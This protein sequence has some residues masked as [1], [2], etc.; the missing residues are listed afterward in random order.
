MYEDS[1]SYRL[2]INWGSLIIKAIL[3]ILFVMLILWLFPVPKL[4][5]FYNRVFSDNLKTMEEAAKNYY[6]GD[7]L[8]VSTGD[9]KTLTLEDMVN[10]NLIVEFVDK[11]NNKCSG[12]NSFAT[13]TKTDANKYVLKVQ[14]SCGTETD[15]ILENIN[16]QKSCNYASC[17]TGTVDNSENVNAGNNIIINNDED[18][19]ENK[20]LENGSYDKDGNLV[21]I[22]EYEFKKPI[23]NTSTNYSCPDGF[24]LE[25]DRCYKY[26]TGETI[27]AT[28]LYFEDSIKIEDA[29]KNETGEYNVY[30]DVVKQEAGVI[31]SCPDG[32]TRNGDVCYKYVEATVNPGSTKYSC[33]AGYDLNGKKCVKVIN[34]TKETNNN[35][36]Y[37]CANG[38]NL[39]GTVCRYNATYHN[40]QQT[41]TTTPITYSCD[42]GGSLSGTT[43]TVSSS[44]TATKNSYWSNPSVT[45]SKSALSEY[46]NGT[47]KRVLANKSCNLSG[48]TYTY[49]TYNL[50]T[51]YSCPNGGS[52]SNGVCYTSTSYQ[53]TQHGGETNCSTFNGYY[54]CDNG[55]NLEGSVCRYDASKKTNTTEK[56]TCPA[57]Y[58]LT[59][60]NKCSSVIDATEDTTETTYSCP[61]GYTKEGT[62]CYR[63]E[64]LNKETKYEYVCPEGYLTEG[65]GDKKKCYKKQAS[66][67]EYYCEEEDAVL[68]GNKCI[69]KVP[70][71]LKGYTCPT[72]YV[73]DGDNC[74]KKTT[75]C[76]K[77]TLD[78]NTTVTYTYKWSKEKELDGWIATGK[79]R[80][81]SLNEYIK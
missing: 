29:K 21:G 46:N 62:T 75:T 20:I 56:Y 37:Y 38:G 71:V 2:K 22:V 53:A 27:K 74:I 77:A 76:I 15:Y 19:E 61:E 51:N 18:D 28:E 55:G 68:D 35:V 32:Y 78:K 59:S 30:V 79:T 67:I 63:T 1:N 7:N 26:E 12:T 50:I 23:Y 24:V 41:C 54:T 72:G 39:D 43:C 80:V 73:L 9:S 40:G 64:K 3:I 31:E 13:I 44:Y 57:G 11:D 6:V 45:T 14:L 10:K 34:A 5:T 36:S 65:D 8:P 70:G 16:I 17:G 81:V 47:Q 48:C 49:Y 52:Q 66:K 42:N 60:D 33:P 58:E 69:K 25:G 4:D